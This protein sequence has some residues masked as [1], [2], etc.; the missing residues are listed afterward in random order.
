M[1]TGNTDLRSIV[2][3]MKAGASEYVVKGSA[4]LEVELKFRLHQAI[5]KQGLQVENQKLEK[6]LS[7]QM[8]RY[9]IVGHSPAILKLKSDILKLKGHPA[10]VLIT[11][12]SGVGK[13][14]VA[15]S[16]SLQESNGLSRPFVA[17]NCAAISENLVESELFGHEKGA[18]TGAINKSKGKFLAAHRG[19]LFLDEIGDMPLAAQAK[20]LRALQE[21]VIT[22]VGST[23]S[24]PI[25]VR[26][27]AATNKDLKAEIQA[28]RFREDLYY[29]LSV[30][31]FEVPPLRERREDIPALAEHFLKQL[32]A[33]KIRLS[34][35]AVLKLQSHSWRGNIRVLRNCLERAWILTRGEDRTVIDRDE[36]QFDDISAPNSSLSGVP[37][38]LLPQSEPEL[39]ADKY[40]R[41]TI[42]SENVFFKAAYVAAGTNKTRLAERLGL[43]RDF[44][45]RK[46]KTLKIGQEGLQQ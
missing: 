31:R 29:R 6:K 36:I 33:N 43:S 38:D 8:R 40:E 26:V 19:D 20:L 10:S 41:F 7:E 45:H 3:A 11:G 21:R 24:I 44:I 30:V 34:D 4:D 46:L 28:G 2:G 39:S 32:G 27:I 1:L 16:L 17:V 5:E 37:S 9:E 12:E 13:E 15:G 22:P 18:F 25:D 23:E 14:M 42:W 35:E